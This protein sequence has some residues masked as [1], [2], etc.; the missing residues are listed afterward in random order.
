MD[1]DLQQNIVAVSE[2]LKGQEYAARMNV[3]RYFNS[4]VILVDIQQWLSNH[5]SKRILDDLRIAAQKH[6]E[7]SCPD[8]DILNVCLDGKDFLFHILIIC[9]ID[10][11]SLVYSNP[12]LSMKM[13]CRLL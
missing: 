13:P 2:D 12:K 5:I 1:I 3:E 4:G 7:M 11:C 10:W 6:P 8:Q 9:P